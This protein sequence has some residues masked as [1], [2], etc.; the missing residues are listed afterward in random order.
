MHSTAPNNLLSGAVRAGK[1]RPLVERCLADAL[2]YPGG[3]FALVRKTRATLEETTLRSFLVDACGCP[4]ADD[5]LQGYGLIKSWNKSKLKGRLQ[6][7]SEIIC[8]GLDRRAGEREPRKI[9]SLELTKT[10]VDEATELEESDFNMLWTRLSYQKHGSD[11]QLFMATNPAG[12]SHWI[13]KRF[14]QKNS[15]CHVGYVNPF[16]NPFL[17]REYLNEL[18]EIPHASN[19]YRRMV[20]GEWIDFLG[21]VFDCF[22]EEKHVIDS[23]PKLSG[24]AFNFRSIDF[25]GRNPFSCSWYRHFP[26]SDMLYHYRQVYKSAIATSEFAELINAAQPSDEPIRYSISDHEVADRIELHKQGIPTAPA[27]KDNKR[28]NIDAVN[29]RLA[30][31]KLF[32]VRDAIVERDP[33][34]STED[35]L[36]GRICPQCTLEEIP[37]Y[38]W[39]V[40]SK[41]IPTEEP[42]KRD[43]HGCDDLLYACASL[44]QRT[45]KLRRGRGI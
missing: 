13:Y 24:K 11:P 39:G 12:K 26:E 43:D 29:K 22:D 19:F 4:T 1:T 18:N 20:L 32:F 34:L 9:G 7:G 33:V 38:E 41:G 35:N 30:E 25:G 16:D 27:K 2:K 37:G 15:N 36:F 5:P 17:S 14:I 3:R 42:V 6:N 31:N 44:I 8:F 28:H 23:V 21:Q 40:D 45:A 10:Y